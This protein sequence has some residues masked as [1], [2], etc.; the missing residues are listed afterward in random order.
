MF[1]NV[2]LSTD[3]TDTETKPNS[4]RTEVFNFVKSELDAVIPLLSE[5]KDA[6]TYGR[7]NKWAALA[8]R[9]KLHLNAEAW[10]GTAS[11]ACSKADADAIINSGVY[12]LEATYSDNF[13]E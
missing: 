6:S 8:L 3:F 10:T 2:P 11:W 9:M 4:S 12:A 5:K 7:M 1:G 13:K